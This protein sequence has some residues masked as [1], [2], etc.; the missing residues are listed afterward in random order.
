MGPVVIPLRSIR[1]VRELP[2]Q[3]FFTRVGGSGGFLGFYGEFRN[4]DLGQVTMYATRSSD[5][6]LLATDGRSYV[7]T[8][9][10]P[11]A[12]VAQVQSRLDAL[13]AGDDG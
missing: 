7:V 10:S 9:D 4:R 1:E 2:R 6:V 3:V 5:R 12:F 11:A 13:R 8:P